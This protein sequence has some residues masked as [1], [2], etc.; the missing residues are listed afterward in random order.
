MN[1]LFHLPQALSTSFLNEQM[2]YAVTGT[3]NKRQ[4]LPNVFA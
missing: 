2:N 1:D 4:L 3:A